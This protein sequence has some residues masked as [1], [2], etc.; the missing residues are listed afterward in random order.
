[1]LL[2]K[3]K[4]IAIE[5]YTKDIEIAAYFNLGLCHIDIWEIQ[6]AIENFEKC[7]DLAIDENHKNYIVQSYYC[8]AFLNSLLDNQERATD[9]IEK[10][11]DDFNFT[12]S[13]AWSTGYRWLFLGRTYGSSGFEG[14]NV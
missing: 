6:L 1:M 13:S 3:I 10:T 2:R 5:F 14:I 9:F 11:F 12:N 7:I 8:L 4:K